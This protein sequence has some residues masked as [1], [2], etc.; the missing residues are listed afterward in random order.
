MAKQVRMLKTY[1]SPDYVLEQGKVYRVNDTLAAELMDGGKEAAAELVSEPDPKEKVVIPSA[2]D[3]GADKGSKKKGG[4][5]V[6][7]E[8]DEE[9]Q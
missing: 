8:D 9:D 3:P 7:D 5:T 6:D 1:A 4:K 2:P